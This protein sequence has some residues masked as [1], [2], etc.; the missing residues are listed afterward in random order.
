MHLKP[1]G[2]KSMLSIVSRQNVRAKTAHLQSFKVSDRI[3]T[4][5]RLDQQLRAIPA[6]QH[7]NAALRGLEDPSVTPRYPGFWGQD[8]LHPQNSECPSRAGILGPRAPTTRSRC[9][10]RVPTQITAISRDFPV[11]DFGAATL[12]AVGHI[13]QKLPTQPLFHRPATLS[14]TRP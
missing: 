8:R 10:T 9:L 5:D 14:S 4:G 12:G 11:G 1:G 6:L 3:R 7:G 13:A 2:D